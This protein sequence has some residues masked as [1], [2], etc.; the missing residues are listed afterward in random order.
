MWHNEFMLQARTNL[1]GAPLTVNAS[2]AGVSLYL[3]N[4]GLV[5]LAKA[6][7]TLRDRFIAVMQGGV[8][9]LFSIT[10]AAEIIGPQGRSADKL[11]ELLD[12]IGPHWFPVE[13]NP[14]EVA[15][16]ER[17]GAKGGRSMQP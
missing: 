2:V 10:N 5:K 9:L 13:M 15:E 1:N 17:Q 8:D 14:H 6:D 7:Q 11:R 12:A 4:F 16:R 3:D